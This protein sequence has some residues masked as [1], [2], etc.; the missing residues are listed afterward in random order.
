MPSHS[1]QPAAP[2]LPSSALAAAALATVLVA[3][4]LLPAA[5]AFVVVLAAAIGAGVT[6]AEWRHA[7]DAPHL[8]L[9]HDE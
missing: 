8:R 7:P 3:A 5:A 4:L 9:V 1:H 2:A 6:V